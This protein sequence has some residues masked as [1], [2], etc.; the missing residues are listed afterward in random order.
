[1]SSIYSGACHQIGVVEDVWASLK[2]DNDILLYL[3]IYLFIYA[4]QLK[5]LK[6]LV[7]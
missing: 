6:N 4:M 2:D 5:F 3:F 7:C 1:M